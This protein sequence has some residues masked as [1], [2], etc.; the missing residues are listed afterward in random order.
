VRGPEK[1][2]LALSELRAKLVKDYLVS[3][4]I[5]ADKIESAEKAKTTKSMSSRLR[6]CNRK[7]HRSRK[8]G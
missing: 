5:A 6:A 8:N 4:G 1:Y 2:D 7:I 3:Q